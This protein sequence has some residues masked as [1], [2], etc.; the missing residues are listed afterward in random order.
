MSRKTEDGYTAGL[1][2]EPYGDDA[3]IVAD[4]P[5]ERQPGPLPKDHV[6]GVGAASETLANAIIRDPVVRALDLG[7]GCGVQAVQ[8][9][10]ACHST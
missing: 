5:S 10:Q 2:L 6:L 4:L 7:T 8:P 1:D 3:W 9:L